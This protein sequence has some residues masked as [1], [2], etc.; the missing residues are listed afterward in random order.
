MTT[1]NGRVAQVIEATEIHLALKQFRLRYLHLL[2]ADVERRNVLPESHFTRIVDCVS[3][4]SP[5][6]IAVALAAERDVAELQAWGSAGKGSGVTELTAT[7]RLR[8]ARTMV[9]AVFEQ[10]R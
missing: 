5:N 10:V 6:L 3:E 2:Q 9:D 4:L 7:E 8:L 1:R